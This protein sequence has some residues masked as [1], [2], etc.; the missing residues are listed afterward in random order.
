VIASPRPV[1]TLVLCV[2]CVLGVASSRLFGQE[3]A[4]PQAVPRRAAS[5]GRSTRWG[6]ARLRGFRTKASRTVRPN[7]RR[8]QAVPALLQAVGEQCGRLCRISSAGA[9]H[10]IQRSAHQDAMRESL[11]SPNDRLARRR[12]SFLSTIH[13]ALTTQSSPRS[14][15]EQGPIRA[16][17]AGACGCGAGCG[18][19]TRACARGRRSCASRSRRGFLPQRGHR[20]AR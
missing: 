10:R 14:D 19:W 2:L 16:S 12:D 5:G 6:Q 20:G 9:S 7:T 4:A 17:I 8:L 3:P 15:K 13:S 18:F 1:D 11:T